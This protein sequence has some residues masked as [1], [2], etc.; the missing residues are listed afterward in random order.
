MTQQHNAEQLAQRAEKQCC[1]LASRARF[2]LG[3]WQVLFRICSCRAEARNWASCNDEHD[4][5]DAD[6]DDD[7]DDDDDAGCPDDDDDDVDDDDDDPYKGT[8][9]KTS[10]GVTFLN[11]IRN[12]FR[13][14]EL[15]TPQ[16]KYDR[17]QE[18]V[19]S[20]QAPMC[21]T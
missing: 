13:K 1:G 3:F 4:D 20:L 17:S 2:C 21:F 19:L 15:A 12:S 6:D 8:A 5:D 10:T 14:F 18:I 7:D 9:S 11:L 16:T